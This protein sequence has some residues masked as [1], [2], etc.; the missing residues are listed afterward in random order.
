M[1]YV[2]Q[3][4]LGIS[5]NTN[6]AIRWYKLAADQGLASAQNNLGQI[7]KNS[8]STDQDYSKAFKWLL[9]AAKGGGCFSSF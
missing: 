7:Y 5:K 3:N 6:E 4:G 9:L 8:A 2:Y 1:G